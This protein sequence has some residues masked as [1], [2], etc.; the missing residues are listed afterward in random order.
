L[1]VTGCG[2]QVTQREV[3]P[4]GQAT[5]GEQDKI[6]EALKKAGIDRDIVAIIDTGESWLVTLQFAGG[7]Q[8]A[9]S[10][11]IP[12][13]ASVNKK[14]YEVTKMDAPSGRAADDR[15][16]GGRVMDPN[17]PKKKG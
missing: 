8:P 3:D 1:A 15:G 12:D 7:P 9:G 17:D 6:K 5:V 16:S 4:L 13:K 2:P 10:R 11:M 14:T